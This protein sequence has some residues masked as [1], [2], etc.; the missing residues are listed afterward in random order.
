M[1]LLKN[2]SDKYKKSQSLKTSLCTRTFYS[3]ICT[4]NEEWLKFR[5]SKR[6]RQMIPRPSRF[7]KCK[8]NICQLLKAKLLSMMWRKS[9]R[10]WKRWQQI[11]SRVSLKHGML[12]SSIFCRTS[13]KELN[14]QAKKRLKSWN[15]KNN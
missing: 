13:M 3:E 7:F 14:T 12:I 8:S 15:S 9:R 1:D 2:R 6:G 11:I 4:L 10:S 5:S